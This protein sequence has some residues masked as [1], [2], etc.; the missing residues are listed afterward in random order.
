MCTFCDVLHDAKQKHKQT[1]ESVQYGLEITFSDLRHLENLV[2][3]LT[4]LFLY[5]F[6]TFS[7]K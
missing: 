6:A 3:L 4:G 7:E 1:L 5:G 2:F